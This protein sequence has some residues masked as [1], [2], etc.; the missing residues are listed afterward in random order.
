VIFVM[1]A[2]TIPVDHLQSLRQ[3]FGNRLQERVSLQRYTAARIGGP[4]DALVTVKTAGELTDAV[5]L[6]C[7][8]GIPFTIMGSGSNILVS[9]AGVRRLVILNQ[10][11]RITFHTQKEPM[12]VW[13]ESGTNFGAL[14]RQA[15]AEGLAGLEWAAGIP[16]TVGGAV[17]GN[18]GAHGGD[19]AG[20]LLVANILQLKPLKGDHLYEISAEEWTVEQFAY[21]YRT[22]TIKHQPGRVAVLSATLKLSQ[23]TPE[24][25]MVKMDEYRTMRK[26]S[27]PSGAS[28]GSIFK[29]P[30]GD[31]AGRL[32]E[33]AGLKGMKIGEVEISHKHANFF[34]SHAGAT[35]SDYARLIR[36]AQERVQEK[37]GVSLELEI[38]LL[39]DWTDG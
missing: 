15:A 11:K 8:Q 37:F 31:Y 12:A 17:Y 39:G 4:A 38:E 19:M 22:S 24:A 28:L 1:M 9:E 14:A 10:A 33:A 13:A 27:Q 23:S 7:E 5:K 36:L 18:A 25:V 29:N 21:G 6:C 32:I 16:G 35:A 30:P 3:A 20:S 2:V 26:N 34:I